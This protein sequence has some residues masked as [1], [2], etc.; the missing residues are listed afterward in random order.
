MYIGKVQRALG[1]RVVCLI[2]RYSNVD[3]GKVASH[4]ISIYLSMRKSYKVIRQGR[5]RRREL[6]Y[7]RRSFQDPSLTVSTMGK[8]DEKT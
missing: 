7:R 8:A 3:H 4:H 1:G 2:I 6:S 5:R